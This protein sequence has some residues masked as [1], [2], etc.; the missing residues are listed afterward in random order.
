[1]YW[2]AGTASNGT[3]RLYSLGQLMFLAAELNMY[4]EGQYAALRVSHA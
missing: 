1:L 3:I 4:C 2:Q